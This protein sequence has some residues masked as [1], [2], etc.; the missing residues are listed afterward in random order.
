MKIKRTDE[1]RISLYIYE[2]LLI[3]LWGKKEKKRG[4]ERGKK[5]RE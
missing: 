2:G 3:S 4:K 1:V 5:E